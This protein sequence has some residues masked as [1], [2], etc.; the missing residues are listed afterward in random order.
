[1]LVIL[2]IPVV[3]LCLVVWWAIRAEPEPLEGAPRP[4]SVAP[5][6]P[7]Q[8]G[9]VQTNRLLVRGLK[10]AVIGAHLLP[11]PACDCAGIACESAIHIASVMAAQVRSVDAVVGAG[12]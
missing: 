8:L 10:P 3:Y 7:L 4:V 5:E 11:Q 9:C 1:M 6:P 12:S 2:K